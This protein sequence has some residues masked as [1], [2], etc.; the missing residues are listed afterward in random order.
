VSSLL[1][2]V[3]IINIYFALYVRVT[4]NDECLWIP[5][6]VAPDSI[7]VFIE[8]VKIEGVSWKAGIRNDDR[9]IAI[10]GKK[11]T[12]TT[13][14][15]IIL[16]KVNE[17]HYADYIVGRDGKTFHTKVYIKKLVS[18]FSLSSCLLAFFWMAIGFIVLLAKPDGFIQKLFYAVGITAVFSSSVVLL[19]MDFLNRSTDIFALVV[20]YF[21]I[22]GS[23]FSPFL[24][25]FFFWSFPRPF[26]FINKKWVKPTLFII[27]SVLFL[28]L[29]PA[30]ILSFATS[31][32][33]IKTV[34]LCLGILGYINTGCV[35]IAWV[36]LIIKYRKL[37][38]KEE[39]KPVAIILAAL[40]IGI[41]ASIY[42]STVAPAI[43]DTIF[44]SPEYYTPMILVVIIPLAF[45][46]SI[47]KY[48]LMDVSVVVKNTLTYGIA[49]VSI[50]LIYF[51]VIYLLGQTISQAIGTE[52]QGLI[53]GIIFII[54]AMVFQSTKD[55]FQD[56]ITSRFYPEQFAYQKVLLKFSNDVST[57]VGLEK[58]LDSM[59][60]TYVNAL[61]IKN[62]GILITDQKT[63]K[64][65][66]VR[67]TG[68]LNKNFEI[69]G[70]S[71]SNFIH[72]K[73]L[74]LKQPVIE[75]EDFINVFPQYSSQ[76]IEDN[77]YTIIPMIIKTKVIGLLL[78]GLKHSGA[79]FAGKDLDLLF[80]TANQSAIAIENARLYHS[81][82]EK[83]TIEN[84]LNLARKI[85]QGL[86]PK[87]LPKIKS[88]DI[89]GEMIPAM[90][91]GGDY[92]D[93]IPISDTKL[94][95]VVGDVSGKGLP[96]SLYM[97]KLQ[98][99]V[100]LSCTEGKS[101][102]EILIDV[103]KRIYSSLERNSFITMTL[104][105]FDVEKMKV[106]FCRAGHMPILTANNGTIDIYK[107]QGLG[108]GLEQGLIFENTLTEQE[109][110]LLP[111]QIY[112]FYSD[113]I[114]EAMN[115]TFDLFGEEKLSELLRNKKEC[116]SEQ[117]M[118][119]IWSSIN[120]F[121]GKAEQNDDMTIVLV[122]VR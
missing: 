2:I 66:L 103:N 117:I 106:R 41:S 92:Y 115:E 3:A 59:H 8:K 13:E 83:I 15:Q 27:P 74:I 62:F 23:C 76:L 19:N 72:E 71:I 16:N 47:F 69:S 121:K 56:F 75:R 49:T 34:Q 33:E 77:I 119:Q 50:A 17:G 84:D 42:A 87:F 97:T 51:L 1:L 46:Y 95:I 79:Q 29:F 61:K 48:Q 102:R 18:I 24:L 25:L 96:A 30:A 105:L 70:L 91:V 53:A 6:Q 63:G 5:E 52:Y 67:S 109:I 38:T 93:V 108:I 44:N 89:S 31:I 9:L 35:L 86:L 94:F 101:P 104:A 32:I 43:S 112:A 98:T 68:I 116:T 81:E 36:S 65:K 39:K 37:L 58:I 12:S 64:L 26:N 57:V 10:N 55:N 85:Q 54:F 113:G 22:L 100:Q 82:A 4:S 40:T 7:E 45:A 110:N 122:K 60:E 80:A 114:T 90:Q 28:I 120:S 118:N 99:M 88:L 111:G 78:F 11:I 73:A 20:T 107:S 14:A 21:F